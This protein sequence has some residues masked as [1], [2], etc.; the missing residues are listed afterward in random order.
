MTKKEKFSVKK[1]FFI[2]YAHRLLN[3]N[4]KCENLHGHNARIEIKIESSKLNSE[5]MVE[6]FTKIKNKAGVWLN[7]NLDHKTIL[8]NR[9]PLVN[10]LKSHKQ[11]MF[12]THE[13]PT[14]EALC[15]IIYENIRKLGFDIK[16]VKF[17]ENETSVA[18]YKKN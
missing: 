7:E 17:W 5:K 14:A 10:A 16:S 2:S 4:G 18:S 11:K 8:S 15:K 6:D 12:L 9:D 3:Y 13:N 1:I